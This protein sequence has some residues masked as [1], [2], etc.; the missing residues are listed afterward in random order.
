MS[1][2]FE[3]EGPDHFTAGALGEPGARTFFLQTAEGGRVL[4]FKCEKEQVG[5][6]GEYLAQVLADLPEVTEG[7]PVDLALREPVMSEWVAGT[8]GVAY[9]EPSD[10]IVLMIEEASFSDAPGG[11]PGDELGAVEEEPATLR[12]RLTRAQVA[13]YVQRARQLIEGGRP[14]CPLCGYPMDPD[15]HACPRTNGHGPPA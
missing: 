13:A 10:R 2:S 12:L 11:E 14:S 7:P 3:L 4:S 6:L 1:E 5:A 15:G 9:D 8:I